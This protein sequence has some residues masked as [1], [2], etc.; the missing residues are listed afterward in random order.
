MMAKTVMDA[1]AANAN[2]KS[3]PF[4]FEAMSPGQL[5]GLVPSLNQHASYQASALAYSLGVSF[6]GCFRP[7]WFFQMPL[8][9]FVSWRALCCLGPFLRGFIFC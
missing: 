1:A 6:F 3:G 5:P 2:L 9:S 8:P 7:C 4:D